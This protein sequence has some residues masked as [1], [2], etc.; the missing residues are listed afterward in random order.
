MVAPAAARSRARARARARP[1][2]V[3]AREPTTA[4]L[5]SPSSAVEASAD[6][7]DGRRIEDA[8]QERGE[9][10]ARPTRRCGRPRAAA[11]RCS[12]SARRRAAPLRS[13]TRASLGEDV[14][15]RVRVGEDVADVAAAGEDAGRPR[16][17]AGQERERQQVERR[18]RPPFRARGA[19]KG[20]SLYGR[21]PACQG[22][23]GVSAWGHSGVPRAGQRPRRRRRGRQSRAPGTRTIAD[24]GTGL[25]FGRGRQLRFQ[26]GPR[27][28]PCFRCCRSSSSFSPL[29]PARRP[30][31]PETS[32]SFGIE[33]AQRGLWSEA[34]FRFERAVA[35]DPDNAEALNNLAVAL[36]QQGEFDKARE[37]YERALKLKPGNLYIQQNYDLFREADD[38]RNRKKKA[39]TPRPRPTRPLASP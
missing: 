38:K 27:R 29:P 20:A 21:P 8:P 1:A 36:E 18:G 32:S 5:R 25:A 16:G 10:R 39:P 33:V 35:L 30:P 6:V 17:E 34:R 11:R 19:P 22:P 23:P 28:T 15:V 26:P 31:P 12:S 13:S 7:E 3:A 9:V 2:G 4:T 37:A 24:G 14:G